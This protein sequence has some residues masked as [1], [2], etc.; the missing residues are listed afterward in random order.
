M[1]KEAV[2][3]L[4]NQA[5]EQDGCL[6]NAET[7]VLLKISPATVGKYIKEWETENN[8]VVPRRGTIHYI[9]PS[10]THKKIIIEKLFIEK[11][12]V[13]QVSRETYHSLQ[14]IQ[15]YISTFKQ[16]LLC[17]K[18]KSSIFIK[19]III[20]GILFSFLTV[21]VFTIK[22]SPVEKSNLYHQPTI[23]YHYNTTC[24]V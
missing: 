2:A 7:A 23:S 5:Y 13:Q 4:H 1:K 22:K 12:T 17:R 20:M 10:L 24:Y 11:K 3:R 18:K 16:V 6:T 9:G 19:N 8:T 14:A 21:A 15:R